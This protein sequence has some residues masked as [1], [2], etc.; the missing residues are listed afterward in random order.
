MFVKLT[1]FSFRMDGFQK[2]F[3]DIVGVDATDGPIVDVS[4]EEELVGSC[5]ILLHI[6]LLTI[7][8]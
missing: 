2:T 6:G 7:P 5:R 3:V 8:S 4:T 1:N